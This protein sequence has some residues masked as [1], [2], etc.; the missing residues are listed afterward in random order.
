MRLFVVLIIAAAL[1]WPISAQ[2]GKGGGGSTNKGAAIQVPPPA[3]AP[4]RVQGANSTE[5][6]RQI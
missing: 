6:M 3:R 2:A 4:E 5:K 1:V